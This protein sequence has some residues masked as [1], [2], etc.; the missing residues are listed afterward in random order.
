MISS[1]IN[2]LI[3]LKEN[4]PEILIDFLDSFYEGSDTSVAECVEIDESKDKSKIKFTCVFFKIKPVF[5]IEKYFST[6]TYIENEE[7]YMFLRKLK[8]KKYIT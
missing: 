2:Q 3:E 4:E 1:L 6:F 7:I 8:L 5:I